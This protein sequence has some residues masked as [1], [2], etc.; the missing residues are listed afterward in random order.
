MAA[1]SVQRSVPDNFSR[2][3]EK[4]SRLEWTPPI[5]DCAFMRSTPRGFAPLQ[6]QRRNHRSYVWTEALYGMVFRAQAPKKSGV[7]W[8]YN[9]NL[10][11]VPGLRVMSFN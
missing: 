6:K 2:R 3:Q 1:V 4:L 10:K 7:L 11:R 8:T 5:C 9:W